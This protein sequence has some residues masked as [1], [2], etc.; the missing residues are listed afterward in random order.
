MNMRKIIAI[1]I[2]F[3]PFNFLR[4]FLYRILLGYKIL[5]NCKIAPFNIIV[6]NELIMENA[7]QIV[8]WGNI[9]IGVHSVQ[10]REGATINKLNRF[11]NFNSMELG[12]RSV[13]RS[14]NVF[15]GTINNVSSFKQYENVFIGS[16]SII[17]GKHSFDLSDEVRIGNDVTF[18]GSGSEIWTHGFD[19]EHT[20]IQAGIIIGNKCYI[21]SR[22]MLMLGCNICDNVSVAGGTVVSKP[23]TESGFYVSTQLIRKSDLPSYRNS[24]HIFEQNDFRIYRKKNIIL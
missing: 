23:I 16:D 5:Y 17:T 18:G 14:Q 2:A 9:I 19:L 21:G 6:C 4:I 24:P 20:K 12:Q 1:G 22:A 10:I 8:G 15:F 3:T 13:I 7:A 11:W